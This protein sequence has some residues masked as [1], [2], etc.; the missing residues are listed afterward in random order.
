MH[1]LQL[2]ERVQRQAKAVTQTPSSSPALARP[3]RL[4]TVMPSKVPAGQKVRVK[5]QQ[6]VAREQADQRV[7]HELAE[8]QQ[9]HDLRDIDD[10]VEDIAT[11]YEWQAQEHN[12]QPKNPAWFMALAAGATLI[13]GVLALLGNLIGAVTMAA[14]GALT[15]F[16]AQREPKVARYRILVDGVAINTLLYHYRDLAAF[17]IVYE[18]GHTKT[19]ILRSKRLLAPLLHMEIGDADPVAIR[20]I[21]LE[22]L[23]EDQ[24]MDEPVVD[25]IARRLGF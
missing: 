13:V 25:I 18:P 16:I 5:T 22:F 8:M 15:Y 3:M 11:L 2:R 7:Q 24:E 17:N 6:R 20:D 12:H 23:R 9:T 14:M 4:E 1:P 19:V 21:L 10:D